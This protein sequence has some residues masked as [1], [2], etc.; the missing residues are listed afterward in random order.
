MKVYPVVQSVKWEDSR[1]LDVYGDSEDAIERAR[2]E[3][4]SNRLNKEVHEWRDAS[5][6]HV[7][8]AR[9]G[10]VTFVVTEREVL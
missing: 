2:E 7:F 9:T 5:E 6:T 8:S 3:A 1:L 10:D 4:G